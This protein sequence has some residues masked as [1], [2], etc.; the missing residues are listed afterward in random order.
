MDII[1][2]RGASGYVKENTLEAFEKAI[3]LGSDMVEFDVRKTVDG[4]L[5]IIHDPAI[6][7]KEIAESSYEELLESA[8]RLG[9]HVP[10]LEE[11]LAYLKEKT[12]LDVEIK[13]EGYE[14]ETVETILKYFDKNDFIIISF[15][16]KVV[17]HIKKHLPKIKVG[18]LLGDEPP[19]NIFDS[20]R[21]RLREIFPFRRVKK[22]GADFVD[23]HWKLALIPFYMRIFRFMGIPMIV[24]PLDN[25]EMAKRL[26]KHSNLIA[27][28]TNYPDIIIDA[29]KN[30]GQTV[31]K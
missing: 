1:A 16:E 28:T 7:G 18:L 29:V 15:R 24:W 2:H 27:I 11:T 25:P 26:A 8:D 20:I 3:E 30:E 23:V 12:R 31:S 9:F 10:T 6:D 22:L 5:I 13:E 14:N 21:L 4:K 19:K 17:S